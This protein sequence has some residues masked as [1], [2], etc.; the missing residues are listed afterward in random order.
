MIDVLKYHCQELRV[1]LSIT[2][3]SAVF[4]RILVV[5]FE[6]P[7][8]NTHT[9]SV[10]PGDCLSLL[11]CQTA[12]VIHNVL[13]LPGPRNRHHLLYHYLLAAL[14]SAQ[15]YLITMN[16]AKYTCQHIGDCLSIVEWNLA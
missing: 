9:N 2:V 4:V 13:W 15:P 3:Y 11:A 6:V 10:K 14:Q 7:G 1:V 5:V 12:T 8:I 16:M